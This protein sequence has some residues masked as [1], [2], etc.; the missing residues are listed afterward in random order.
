MRRPLGLNEALRTP[1]VCRLNHA[2]RLH[3]QLL[4]LER[5]T[6]RGTGRDIVDH[7]PNSHD[8]IANAA[9]G[10]LLACIAGPAPMK[11]RD[12]DVER[13]R[14]MSAIPRGARSVRNAIQIG[15]FPSS[16]TGW[17]GTTERNLTHE[18]HSARGHRQGHCPI[19]VSLAKQEM[20]RM[21]MDA[22][23]DNPR[24]AVPQVNAKIIGLLR[25]VLSPG[26]FETAMKLLRGEEVDAGSESA[27]GA[28]SEWDSDDLPAHRPSASFDSMYGE[29]A[30]RIGRDQCYGGK[31][32]KPPAMDIAMAADA[33]NSFDALFPGVRGRC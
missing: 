13:M 28:A 33:A 1:S 26:N 5:R 18:P 2:R 29:N 11:I 7:S 6:G 20:A 23:P 4:G 25:R 12:A 30:K 10:A 15:D 8:D 16:W 9:C 27:G 14:R 31:S 17:R 32:A 22:E 24:A 21:A 3:S 19:Y